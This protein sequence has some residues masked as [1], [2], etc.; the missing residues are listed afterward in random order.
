MLKRYKEFF[1][2]DKKNAYPLNAFRMSTIFRSF[3][4][5]WIVT[6]CIFVVKYQRF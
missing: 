1:K 2:V 5:F 4:V 6:P 3:H